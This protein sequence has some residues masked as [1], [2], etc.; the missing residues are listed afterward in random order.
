MIY[1]ALAMFNPENPAKELLLISCSTK[2]GYSYLDHVESAIRELLKGVKRIVFV[3]FALYDRDAYAAKAG[4][5][6]QPDGIHT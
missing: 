3:P 6:V 4:G 2:Y 1:L 5:T